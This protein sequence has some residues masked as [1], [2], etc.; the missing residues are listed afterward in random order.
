MVRV[1]LYPV[2]VDKRVSPDP[3]PQNP[4]EKKGN[5]RSGS[6]W[7]VRR[8]V[9]SDFTGL[10][11]GGPDGCIGPTV[12]RTR[13][14]NIMYLIIFNYFYHRHR[15][16]LLPLSLTSHSNRQQQHWYLI[17]THHSSLSLIVRR[18]RHHRPPLPSL[19]NSIQHL[20]STVIP[21]INKKCTEG[22]NGT[23]LKTI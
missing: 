2:G 3:N 9:K 23:N 8:M 11:W 14:H 18:D 12:I 15:F 7:R 17:L 4:H 10:V 13:P 1:S 20:K 22:N 16:C 19:I 21:K 6:V 5:G